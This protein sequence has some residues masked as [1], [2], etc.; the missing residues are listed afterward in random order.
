M[1]PASY[2]W[3]RA[4][5]GAIVRLTHYILGVA[6][7]LELLLY[8]DDFIFVADSKPQVEAIGLATGLISVLSDWGSR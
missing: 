6:F 7:P 8:S 3:S 2:H 4:A 1:T 5:A